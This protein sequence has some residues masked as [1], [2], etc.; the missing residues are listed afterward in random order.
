M[1]YKRLGDYIREV[2][3]RNRD[4]KVTNLLGMS[5]SKKFIPSIANTIG[6]DMSTYK[7]IKRNQ[8][9]YVPVTSRNGEKITI[10]LLDCDDE[11]II[12]QAYTVFEIV[13]HEQL[14]PKY[15]M[16]WFR[17]PEFDRYARFHSHGS[18]REVFDWDELCEV[19]LPVPTLARQREIVSEYETLGSRIRLNEQMIA[20]LEETAQ[21]LY[22]KM[23]V[24]GIDKENLPEGWR[25]GKL[26]EVCSKI[27]SGATP[28]GGKDSYSDI[29]ISLIRSMNV[30]DL[31]F[32]YDDLAHISD[33]QAKQLDSVTVKKNDILFNITGA[34]VARCCMV[35]DIILPARVNQHVMIIRSK[36][37]CMS[38]YLLCVLCSDEAKQS[39]LGMSQSGSTRE[40]ITKSEIESFKIIIPPT[41]LLKN[42]S[43]KV[44]T[45][46]SHVNVQKQENSK[47]TELQSLLLARMGK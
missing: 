38:Y 5:I 26:G 42:F 37:E 47:L 13:N 3:L 45:I 40:A 36:E 12:S 14:L 29:G 33:D 10:A 11:A 43:D 44:G 41:E 31:N 34:S 18:A 35:P 32:C 1:E 17:R 22:R 7:I 9:A 2:N 28:K 25:W 8:F 4:L 39:L 24:E 19:R 15:L 23:F 30:F 27:G 16:M 6:T 20:R 46:F 21:A